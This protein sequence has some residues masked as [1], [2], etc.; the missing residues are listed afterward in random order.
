MSLLAAVAGGACAAVAG[1][2]VHGVFAPRSQLYGRVIFR[3]DR[4]DPPRVALSFDDGPHPDATQRVLDALGELGVK[5]A[6]FVIG[7]NIERAADVVAH[8]HS[9]GHLIANHTYE[10]AHLGTLRW[11][12]YW[13]REI[14]R[15]DAI[16]EQ[17][18]G[19]RP[20]LFRP[21]MGFKSP[22]LCA[23]ARVHRH[24]LV[25]WT[26][27]AYDGVHTTT[28][29]ILA[30][31]ADSA[32]AGDI[33]TMHDGIDRSARRS[34]DAT[35]QAVGPLVRAW[36]ARGLEVARLDELIGLAPYQPGCSETS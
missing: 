23:A 15:T 18:I 11:R 10:H 16:I 33:M 20:A 4:S 19:R 3:G 21:P 8:A 36:R 25:T 17:V 5:A 28:D 22:P 26:R 34:L 32:A 12:S 7:R 6:F 29:R 24:C 31:L 14:E 1:T 2:M 9:E 27:R 35:V 13:R 30:R